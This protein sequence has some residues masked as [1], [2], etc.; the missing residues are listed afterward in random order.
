MNWNGKGS[1]VN[2]QVDV[3]QP[4]LCPVLLTV[5]QKARKD[6]MQL[7]VLFL[8]LSLG[9]G[10]V[11][12]SGTRLERGGRFSVHAPGHRREQG[13]R[14]RGL[15]GLGLMKKKL[16]FMCGARGLDILGEMGSGINN[17]C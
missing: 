14:G 15:G 16:G 10:S 2:G 11:G 5:F 17:G 3:G 7:F 13:W 4:L 6:E 8:V 12:R 9:F 1:R